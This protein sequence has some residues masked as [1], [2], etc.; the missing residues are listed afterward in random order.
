MRKV[1]EM[2]ANTNE[3]LGILQ[4]TGVFSANEICRFKEKVVELANYGKQMGFETTFLYEFGFVTKSPSDRLWHVQPDFSAHSFPRVVY[5]G[6]DMSKIEECVVD[7]KGYTN[8]ISLSRD[9]IEYA[10]YTNDYMVVYGEILK[11]ERMIT[12]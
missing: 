2:V 9:A 12:E 7:D 11:F 10:D 5:I 3:S 4:S 8:I 6:K 1:D